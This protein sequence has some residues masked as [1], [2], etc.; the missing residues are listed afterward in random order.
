MKKK[1]SLPPSALREVGKFVGEISQLIIYTDGAARGNPGPAGAGAVLSTPEGE[2]RATVSQ[3]LGETTNNQAEYM[4]L[5]LALEEALKLGAKQ[6]DIRADSELMVKQI[7]GEYRVKNHGLK[8][9][10]REISAMLSKFDE[11]T[12]EHVPREKNADADDLA[13]Q[14]IDNHFK[15]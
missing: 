3:Y 10:F 6:I 8:L 2:T 15:K 1:N 12:A 7:N 9:I 13:N 5:K 14:A 11:W 4:A